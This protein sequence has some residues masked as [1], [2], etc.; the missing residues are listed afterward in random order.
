ML[1][2]PNHEVVVTSIHDYTP[3]YR[4]I[5]FSAPDLVADLEPFPTLW[6]RLWAE[7]ASKAGE[8]AQR[9]YTFVD[10]RP[11]EGTFALDVVLHEHGGPVGRWAR[12][13]QVGERREVALTPR[14]VR[15]PKGADRLLLLGDVSALPAINSWVDCY[16]DRLPIVVAIEDEHAD[17]ELLPQSAGRDVCW[18]WVAPTLGSS[19]G[20]AL[21]EWVHDTQTPASGRYAWGAGEKTLIKTLRPV[22]RDHLGLDRDHHFT[23]F[24]WIEG[25]PFS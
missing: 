14:R 12:G 1:R 9:G 3:W 5:T 4:R 11:Q 10:V 19:R 20:T 2:I 23:Q 21:A 25:R 6:L 17:H 8:L 13:A 18:T 22:L 24:Y 15:L 7:D 16:G